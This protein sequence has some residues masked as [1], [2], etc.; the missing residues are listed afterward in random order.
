MG[1]NV[2]GF[3]GGYLLIVMFGGAVSESLYVVACEADK[4]C[5]FVFNNTAVTACA[6]MRIKECPATSNLLFVLRVKQLP[7]LSNRMGILEP[8]DPM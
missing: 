6:T 8:L 2:A 3:K 7:P 4:C 5:V 1:R